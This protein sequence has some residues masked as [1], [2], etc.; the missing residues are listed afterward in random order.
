MKKVRVLTSCTSQLDARVTQ[1]EMIQQLLVGSDDHHVG[2]RLVGQ[3][4]TS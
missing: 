2:Q 4:A 3:V 1:I